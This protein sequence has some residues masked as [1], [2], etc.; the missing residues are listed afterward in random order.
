MEGQCSN[1]AQITIFLFVYVGLCNVTLVTKAAAA[2]AQL[3]FEPPNKC[4]TQSRNFRSSAQIS[5]N[6]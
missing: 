5:P 1:L 2:V 6:N 3:N 4:G